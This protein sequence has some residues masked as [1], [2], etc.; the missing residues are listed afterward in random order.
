MVLGANEQAKKAIAN[1]ASGVS[2]RGLKWDIGNSKPHFQ[3]KGRITA[4]EREKFVFNILSFM[5]NWTLY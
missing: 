2:E 3:A 1:K 5:G 4:E